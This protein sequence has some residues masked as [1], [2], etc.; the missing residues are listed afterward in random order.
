MSKYKVGDRVIVRKD[1]EEWEEY[2][3]DNVDVA[4]GMLDY[5]GKTLTISHILSWLHDSYECEE[6]DEIYTW[7]ADMFVGF[8][9]E[10]DEPPI[11]V[12]VPETAA[13]NDRLKAGHSFLDM[14]TY[15]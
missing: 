3:V 5:R 15:E 4:T 9:E 2:G 13:L 6:D 14:F 12:I 7:S 10:Y 11:T 8:A 1:L